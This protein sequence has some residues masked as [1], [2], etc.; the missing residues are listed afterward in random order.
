M[1]S[2][3][4][5]KGTGLT[6]MEPLTARVKDCKNRVGTRNLGSSP[7][8]GV[9]AG[10]ECWTLKI[11]NGFERCGDFCTIMAYLTMSFCLSVSV[12]PTVSHWAGPGISLGWTSELRA[13]YKYQAPW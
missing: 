12:S 11:S 13:P 6:G 8:P 10:E 2:F 1:L 7:F 3:V 9:R 4:Y 5:E